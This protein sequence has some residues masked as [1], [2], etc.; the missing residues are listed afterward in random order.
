MNSAST[1]SAGNLQFRL[2]VLFLLLAGCLIGM[3]SLYWLTAL[4]PRLLAEANSSAAALAQSHSQSLADAL[5]SADRDS[6]P[7]RLSDVIDEILVLVDPNTD[8]PFVMGIEIRANTDVIRHKDGRYDLSRGETICPSCFVTEV[9][10]YSR[11]TRELLGAATFRSSNVAFQRLREEVR[12][13]LQVGSLAALLILIVV[14]RAVTALFLRVKAGEEAAM[15]ATRAKSQFLAVMS[16]EIRTPMN[17]ILGM[18]HLLRRSSLDDEQK[19][20]VQTIT[21]SGEALLT[22]LNDILDLSRIE[23]GKLV[24]ESSNFNLC[25]LINDVLRLMSA[26]LKEKQLSI[27]VDLPPSPLPRLR[28]DAA[29]LRQVLLNL[30]GNAIKFT[31][32]GSIT[33][34]VQRLEDTSAG[35]V[36]LELAIKDSGIGIATERQAQL[37]A[38]FTQADAGIAQRFGGSGLGLAICKRL[39]EAMGGNIGVNS[40]LGQGSTFWVRLNFAKAGDEERC[41]EQDDMEA[42]LAPLPLLKILV[43]DDSDINR[44]VASALLRQEG[45]HVAEAS[46]GLEAVGAVQRNKYDV[47]LM[48]LQMPEMNGLEA[49]ESIRGL[50]QDEHANVPIIALTANILK[51]EE[52]R[53][54]AAGMD[55]YLV[56]P[57]TPTGLKRELGRVLAKR[58]Q[59]TPSLST[60]NTLQAK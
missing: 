8:A 9:A 29:H 11:T 20:L 30:V 43:A 50:V 25:S 46:N 34:S 57:F 37:F 23:S 22:I 2:S 60:A 7:R 59:L 47:V 32:R 56:K 41:D 42:E 51:E 24:L 4:E 28:G 36:A 40:E 52:E 26:R 3:L 12:V 18:A 54:F 31:E 19:E 17:G 14:W 49:T 45:H 5:A 39:V 21:D 44:R 13:R 35:Y 55:G 16:H 27:T 6:D 33:V 1:L 38:P 15:V 58:N 10:L 53:C 48:D